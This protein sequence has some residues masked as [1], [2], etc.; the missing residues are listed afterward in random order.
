MI[1]AIK[2]TESGVINHSL[3]PG[4]IISAGDLIASLQLKDPSRVKQISSFKDT[5]SVVPASPP[6]TVTRPPSPTPPPPPLLPT[7]RYTLYTQ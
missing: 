6:K 2:S 5:L 4:S 7:M 1:M 3:S